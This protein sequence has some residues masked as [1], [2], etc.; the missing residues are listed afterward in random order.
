MSGATI[1]T[2]TTMS[3]DE[4]WGLDG[5]IIMYGIF[6]DIALIIPILMYMVLDDT[7]SYASSH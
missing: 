6:C 3:Q 4:P 5:S 7:L 1:T 2:T